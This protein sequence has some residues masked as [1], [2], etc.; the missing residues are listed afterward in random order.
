MNNNKKILIISPIPTHPPVSGN[1]ARVLALANTIRS[2]KYDVYFLH[3]E[4]RKGDEDSMREY[5]GDRYYKCAYTP[6]QTNFI[7]K[8]F[9][10]IYTKLGLQAAF[11]YK[12]DEWYDETSNLCIQKLQNKFHFDTV[13][14][15]YVFFSKALDNFGPETTKILDTHDVFTDRHKHYLKQGKKPTWYST[16]KRNESKGL[17][18]ADIIIAIQNKEAT[19]FSTICSKTVVVVGHNIDIKRVNSSEVIPNRVLFVASNNTINLQAANFLINK[20]LP[21]V[22]LKL[23]DIK[24]AFAG[25]ISDSLSEIDGI[26]IL[27]RVD[28]LASIYKTAVVVVNPVFIGTGL[29]IK[30]IEALAHGKPLVTT[31]VGAEGLEEHTKESFLIGDTPDNFAEAV[32]K[33]LSNTEYAKQLSEAGY[34]IIDEY[35]KQNIE[36]INSIL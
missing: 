33:L 23:P 35:N 29:K 24:L 8:L 31:S 32:V 21:K 30:T 36:I 14:V 26:E 20:V 13:I 7:S 2:E 34:N 3:I 15:E 28:D 5:W 27:G 1:K 9:K 6:P 22:K 10:H 11:R 16:S 17:N 25:T 4:W 18:R 12:L 19:F